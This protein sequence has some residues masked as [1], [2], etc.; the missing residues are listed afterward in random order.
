MNDSNIP[1]QSLKTLIISMISA[2]L[3]AFVIFTTFVAPAEFGIDPTGL[4]KA[5]G[6]TVLAKSIQ[7]DAETVVSCPPTEQSEDWLNVVVITVPANSGLEYKF[8]LKKKA[9]LAYTWATDGSELY[10]DFHGEPEGDTSGYFKSFNESTNDQSDGILK[11]PFTGLHGWYWKNNTQTPVRVTLKT[12][13]QYTIK[14]L[15]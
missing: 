7:E 2:V 5:M 10:F 9:E 13:G 6:L 14:G 4:G 8:H 15:M 1:V 11:A 3:L 12:K